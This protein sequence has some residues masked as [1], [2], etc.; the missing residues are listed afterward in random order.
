LQAWAPS[1]GT[2][3]AVLACDFFVTV[4]ASSRVVYVFIVLEVGTRR[5][6]HWNVTQR[7]TAD[8]IL[9]QFRLIV[10]GDQPHRSSV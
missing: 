3:R 6:V 7:P 1:F 5:I 9:H 10:H 8:W 2:T 4:T